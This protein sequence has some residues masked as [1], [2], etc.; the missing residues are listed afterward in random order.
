MSFNCGG[1]VEQSR[2]EAVRN[3]KNATRVRKTVCKI[4]RKTVRK[5]VC[6]KV[7]KK[8]HKMGGESVKPVL[9]P[10]YALYRKDNRV[11]CDSLQ[12][13]ETFGRQHKHILDTI[14]R[15]TA[16]TSGLSEA[17]KTV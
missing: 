4:V 5:K 11:F 2:D 12:I 9:N 1:T 13:A 3:G 17:F 7:R 16:P 14:K 15:L 6:K 10:N 8:V